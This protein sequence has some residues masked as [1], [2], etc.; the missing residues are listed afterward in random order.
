MSA[1]SLLLRYDGYMTGRKWPGITVFVQDSYNN[2]KCLQKKFRK[3]KVNETE[4]KYPRMKL[5]D[6]GTNCWTIKSLF[7]GVANINCQVHLPLLLHGWGCLFTHHSQ[8]NN[9]VLFLRL[10][11][12]SFLPLWAYHSGFWKLLLNEGCLVRLWQPVVYKCR[13]Q[14]LVECLHK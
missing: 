6:H 13:L 12:T 14:Q 3:L 2:W 8:N 9:F 10:T 11:A 5:F 4:W 7:S 1:D